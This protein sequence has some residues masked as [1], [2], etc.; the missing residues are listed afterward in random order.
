MLS[1]GPKREAKIQRGWRL[2]ES[3]V[4]YIQERGSKG[5]PYGAETRV[6]EEALLLHQALYETLKE[7]RLRLARYAVDIE[8]DVARDEPKIIARLVLTGLDAHEKTR[9]K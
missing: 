6:V 7:Q 1:D 4:K 5:A 9:K 8:A 3:V 2:R